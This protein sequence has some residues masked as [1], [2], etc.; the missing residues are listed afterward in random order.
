LNS[1]IHVKCHLYVE[2]QAKLASSVLALIRTGQ[3]KIHVKIGVSSE[4]KSLFIVKSEEFPGRG[5]PRDGQIY[6]C[7]LATIV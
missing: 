7:T 5:S 4:Y 2:Y 6:C 3:F 1:H